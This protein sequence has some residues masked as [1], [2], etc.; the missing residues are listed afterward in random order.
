MGGLDMSVIDAVLRDLPLSRDEVQHLIR[1]APARYKVHEIEKRHGRGRRVIAQPTAEV[2]LIQRLML[3]AYI[4][5]LPVSAA[6]TAYRQGL[7]IL[8]HAKPHAANKYLL[9]LDFK[10]FFPS[11][12]VADFVRH[13]RLFS[14]VS[15]DDAKLLGR[16][17]FWR[18]KGQRGLFLSIGA[19]SSPAIS[20]TL[21]Y[22][23]DSEV[24]LYCGKIGVVYTRYADDLAFSTNS[25]D[26]LRGVHEFVVALCLRLKNPKLTVN[27]DKT[28]YTSMKHHRE[29]TGLVLSNSGD[30]S[31]GREKKRLIRAMAHRYKEGR[32]VL[33]EQSTLRGLLA[34]TLSVDKPFVEVI[35]KMVGDSKFAALMRG[36]T[37][38]A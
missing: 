7:G 38:D 3:R 10:D 30:A 31:I 2:K 1:T 17:F 9:K 5:G 22:E 36:G 11:I 26:V 35:R 24:L 25:P 19:P 8:D 28:V 23:F 21:L 15:L 33:S 37:A 29:L 14:R 6:A 34:F 20:N 13:L 4:D 16:L 18:P 32:L 12:R 27:G